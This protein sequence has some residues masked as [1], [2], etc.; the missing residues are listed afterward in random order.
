MFYSHLVYGFITL[1]LL[2]MIIRKKYNMFQ[3]L[4]FVLPFLSWF[5]NI[6]LNLSIFQIVILLIIAMNLISTVLGNDKNIIHTKNSL[7]NIFLLYSI[8]ITLFMSAFIIKDFLQ[9]GGFFRSEGRFLSQIILWLL[10]FSLIPIAYNYIKSK[11]SIYLYLKTYLN[12]IIVLIILGWIQY[13]VYQLSG[14]DIFPIDFYADGTP[15]TGMWGYMGSGIFRICSLGGEPKGFSQSLVMAF[16]IIQVSNKFDY[17]Y[18]KYDFLLKILIVITIFMTLS[19]SGFVL[20]IILYFIYYI[21]MVLLGLIQ[22]KFTV[23]NIILSSLIFFSIF[24]LINDNL[25][26]FTSVADQRLLNRDIASEDFDQ[27]I[28]DFLIAQPQYSIFGSGMGNIHNLA[29][30]YISIKN[31]FYMEN[32]IFVAKSG[33]LKI[34]SELGFIGLS[35]FLLMNFSIIRNLIYRYKSSKHHSTVYL[36]VTILLILSVFAVLARVYIMKFYLLV[37]AIAISLSLL[38]RPVHEN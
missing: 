19:T 27:P 16:F 5:Y 9:L 21:S 14:T 23:K 24:Y 18:F 20:F 8:F 13:S 7:V 31:R 2:Y 17:K 38:K 34:I 3:V 33:Y 28:Q 10:Y 11:D 29:E 35:L 30:G 25:D 36:I 26:F 37:L 32:T 6:G 12:A 15:R 1:F 4:I 22:I